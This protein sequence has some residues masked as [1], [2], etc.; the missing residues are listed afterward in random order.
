MFRIPE[1][2]KKL[3]NSALADNVP[4]LLGTVSSEGVPQVG[5][6]GSVLVYDDATL[7]YWERAKRSAHQNV[8]VN[9][10]VVVYYRN[11]ARAD[12]LPRGAALR[13]HGVAEVFE[14]GPV[15]EKVKTM[16]V[17][18]ELDRDTDGSGAAVLV[19]LEKITDLQGN[20]LFR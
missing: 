3:V 19:R 7:A 1:E 20:V 18:E 4:C 6:K 10:K 8:L 11:P 17:R 9:P 5:P 12:V 14:T 16:V 2:I 15:R 13:F